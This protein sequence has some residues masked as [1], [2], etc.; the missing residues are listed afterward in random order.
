MGA[1][2]LG[3]FE[4]S[5]ILL[6]QSV[7]KHYLGF[8]GGWG[9]SVHVSPNSQAPLCLVC[10][11][12]ASRF[13]FPKHFCKPVR[14]SLGVVLSFFLS[15]HSRRIWVSKLWVRRG[16]W[17]AGVGV[18]P[19][20]LAVAGLGQLV[21]EGRLPGAWQT[22]SPCGFPCWRLAGHGDLLSSWHRATQGLSWPWFSEAFCLPSWHL[23]LGSCPVTYSIAQFFK[24]FCDTYMIK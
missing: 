8:F 11:C 6:F 20:A 1:F 2:T 10:W 5:R 16:S 21:H 7:S 23:T 18:L 22:A 15:S 17:R 12:Q 9:W 3:F 24:G 19:A 4:P 14:K 13:N